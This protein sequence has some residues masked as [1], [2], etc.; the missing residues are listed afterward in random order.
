MPAT[1]RYAFQHVGLDRAEH[2]RED[3]AALDTLWPAARVLALD[4]DGQV[5]C[6]GSDDQPQFPRGADCLPARPAAASFLGLDDD[7]GAWFALP[8]GN[9]DALPDTAVDLRSAGARW[10]AREAAVFAQARGLLH[11]QTRARFCGVCGGA[12]V[13]ERAGFC[14]RCTSCGIEHYPRTDPAIIV[15]VSD[16]ERL[17][18]GRQASWPDKRWSVLAGFMEPGESLEQTVAREVMEESGVR[19][20]G[21]RYVGSQPW[22]FPGA[23]ML[24]F[25]ADADPQ[26]AVAGAELQ[27]ARWFSAAE[28]RDGA[29]TR[30]V[31]LSPS[32][33]I[34]RW[35]IDD[36]LARH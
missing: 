1:R 34:S 9:L 19:V 15:A 29:A 36:W 31:L 13:L 14:G 11:W 32:L 33:S 23:L 6:S 22:P 5:F 30:E 24:G 3:A 7:G 35:L 12:L 10:P 16:G 20:R 18:L 26:P 28:L 2:L 8:A 21:S 17:L 25:Q 27:D 4:A